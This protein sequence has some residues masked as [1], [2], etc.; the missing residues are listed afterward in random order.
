MTLAALRPA[1]VTEPVPHDVATSRTA[2]ADFRTVLVNI[3]EDFAM[4]RVILRTVIDTRLSEHGEAV[5]AEVCA[6][7]EYDES[8]DACP[9]LM[10]FG[11]IAMVNDTDD[12]QVLVFD[13]GLCI[14]SEHIISIRI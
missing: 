8:I 5:L 2:D 14:R 1:T 4:M 3:G 12:S 11:R 7:G 10:S 9:V 13:D 6:Y